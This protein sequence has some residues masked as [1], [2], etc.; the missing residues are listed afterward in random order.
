MRRRPGDGFKGVLMI[1][2]NPR[3]QA[4]SVLGLLA[5]AGCNAADGFTGT[6]GA[7]AAGF[8]SGGVQQA[9]PIPHVYKTGALLYAG[10]FT[11]FGDA[12]SLASIMDSHGMSYRAVSS[13]ELNNMS[14]DDLS[15]YGAIVW[16][17]GYATEMSN[18]LTA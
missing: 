13:A 3:I 18:S 6:P 11:A 4:V 12:E 1:L 5:L 9:T 17:G 16:P 7:E 14:L 2:S 8:G 15:Q 10:E